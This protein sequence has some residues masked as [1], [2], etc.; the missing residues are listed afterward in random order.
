MNKPEIKYIRNKSID[1]EKWDRCVGHAANRRV[2][3]LSWFLDIVAGEW[4]AVIAGDYDFVMPLPRRSKYG[5][6]YVYPPVYCQQLGVFPLPPEPIHRAMAACLKK[7]FRYVN[8]Q[9]NST[10]FPGLYEGFS[11]IQKNN[12][13]LSLGSPYEIL[14]AQFSSHARRNI[15]TA[16]K[17][18]VQV[19]KGLLPAEYLKA[20]SEAAK[21]KTADYK[22]LLKLISGSILKGQGVVY[23]AYSG[24][25]NLC[26]A[27]FFLTDANRVYYLNAFSTEEGK[28]KRAMY[29]IVN[30]FLQEFAGGGL[31][32]DFEGSVLDGIA[33]FYKGF[34]AVEENYFLLKS[35]RLPLLRFLKK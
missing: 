28:K 10:D 31:I 9:I 32:L 5:L 1:F 12:L 3:A 16:A 20:K 6:R 33:R 21:I 11:F 13:V 24:A 18:G 35:N 34:G 14:S 25:N 29:A 15:N 19:V 27:A 8:Y 2:Y 30:R 23:A 26:A 17:L 4:D 22:I 7:H